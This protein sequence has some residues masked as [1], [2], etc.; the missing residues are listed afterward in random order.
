MPKT[1]TCCSSGNVS[2]GEGPAN[3][4]AEIAN[5]L[6][7]M[8]QPLTIL[9][10]SMEVLALPPSAGVDQR[11]YR[12]ISAAQLERT[13]DLF[14][15]VQ[16]LVAAR[17][18]AAD[19]AQYELWAVI[20][21]LIDAERTLLQA[22][23][24][25]VATARSGPWELVVGD[26]RRTEYAVAAVLRMAGDLALRGDV[27]EI[28]GSPLRGFVE[29]TIENTRIHRRTLNSSARLSLALAKENI[30]SQRGRYELTED[31][32]RVSLAL[33]VEDFGRLRSETSFSTPN[34]E[35]VH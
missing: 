15:Q 11:R 10:A 24:A 2:A 4:Y 5:G 28:S 3:F 35:A 9:R 34:A 23:G 26:A 33:P 25:G 31:P 13:C 16:D 22:S 18:I 27:I 32:F 17:S 6:H 30:L 7:A 8:A 12:E 29:L 19:R 1:A 21:P 20:A 14:T